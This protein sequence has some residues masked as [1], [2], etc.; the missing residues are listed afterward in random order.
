[1]ACGGRERG[2]FRGRIDYNIA[3]MT[4]RA[5]AVSP[6][7]LAGEGQGEGTRFDA[8]IVRLDT[9]AELPS[10]APAAATSR[11]AGEANT[12]DDVAPR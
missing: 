3:S 1:M 4:C 2:A 9:G 6:L 7:P 8:S 12:Y 10:P 11:N 5:Y